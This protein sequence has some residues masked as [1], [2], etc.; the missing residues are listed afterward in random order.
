[1]SL[2]VS[3]TT[4]TAGITLASAN[5]PVFVTPGA[6]VFGTTASGF[7]GGTSAAWTVSNSGQVIAASFGISLKSGG[8]INNKASGTLF[9]GTDGIYAAGSLSA[10]LTVSNAGYIGGANTING[11][12][13]KEVRGAVAVTNLATGTIVGGYGGVYVPSG[14]GVGAI[15]NAGVVRGL[16][17]GAVVFNGGGG[18]TNASTG[19]ITGQEGIAINTTAGTLLNGGTIQGKTFQG[20]IFG[21]GGTVT[22]TAG[23]AIGGAQNGVQIST[24]AGTVTN[25][26]AI[27]GG[28]GTG[29]VLSAGGQLN[30]QGSGTIIGNSNGIYVSSGG[31][32]LVSAGYIAG[33]S[34]LSGSGIK[35]RTGAAVLSNLSGGTIVGGISGIYLVPGGGAGTVTNRGSISGLS[36]SGILLGAGGGV[37]NLG[38]GTITGGSYGVAITGGAGTVTNAGS[39]GGTLKAVSLAAGNA[40]RVIVDPGASFSGVVNG[41]NTIGAAAISTLELAA[42]GTLQAQ[43][44]GLGSQFINFAQVTVDAAAAWTLAGTNTLAAGTTLT[45]AGQLSIA[46]GSLSDAGSVINNGQIIDLSALK[47]GTLSGTGQVLIGTN[48]VFTTSGPVAASETIVFTGGGGL[49]TLVPTGFSGIIQGF[50]SGCAIDLSGISNA[51]STSIVNGNT[52][53]VTLASGGPINLTLAPDQVYNNLIFAIQAPGASFGTDD[54]IVVTGPTGP[55]F[56]AGGMAESLSGAQATSLAAIG[57]GLGGITVAGANSILTTAISSFAVGD[58][59]MGSLVIQSAGAVQSAVSATIAS[60]SGASGSHVNVSGIGSNWQV[61]GTLLV[62]DAGSGLLDIGTGGAVSADALQLG[63]QGAGGAGVVTLAGTGASLDVIGSVAVGVSGAGEFSVLNG[64][65]VTIGG[66]LNVAQLPGASGNV[67]IE[68]TTGTVTITGGITLGAGGGVAVLTIGTLT[69]VALTGG[70]VIG[71]HANLIKHTPFDPPPFV[72]NAGGDNEGSGADPYLAYIENTGLI[73]QDQ[74]TLIVQ[75]PT[76]YGAGGVFQINTNHSELVLNTGGVSGQTFDFTDNTGTLVIGVNQLPTIETP[77]TGTSGFT[78]VANPSQGLALIGSFGGTIGGFQPGD[79]IVVDAP[80]VAQVAYTAGNSFVSVVEA[81]NPLH[82]LGTLAFSTPANAAAAAGGSAIVTEVACFAA[83][84]R[85]L[86][87]RGAI[88]V[89]HLRE[90]DQVASAFGGTVPVVWLGHR[91]VDCRRHP[92]P[93]DVWPVRVHAGAFGPDLP[94]RDLLLS[95]DH[96]VYVDDVLIPVRYLLN[97]ATIAQ[98]PVDEVTYWHVELAQHDVILA[99]GLPAESYLDTGNRGAF[100]NAGGAVTMAPDFALRVWQ[101]EACAPLVTEGPALAAAR[102]RLL[103]RAEALGHVSTGDAALHVLAAGRPVHPLTGGTHPRFRLPPGAATLHFV[104][105]SGIPALMTPDTDDHRRLG[106]AIARITL[107]GTPIHLADPR[108]QAGWHGM[109][110]DADGGTLRWTD[111]DAVLTIADGGE[112]EVEVAMTARYWRAPAPRIAR[113]A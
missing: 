24:T 50:E 70:V 7:Y 87:D 36:S 21:N 26:G 48:S 6:Y 52:L 15:T 49:L 101:A 66:D 27:T 41:G 20:L 32:T 68:N 92:R 60:G 14:G 53:S 10:A 91:R 9:G 73:T 62:G 97:D 11:Y 83:G 23:G 96:A 28:T 34:P 30:N 25:S 39:I 105:R 31:L 90:G 74:G 63:G 4:S 59:T 98:T 95:P 113:V 38:G 72:S 51:T 55:T 99:E 16:R 44:A 106:I 80:V 75:T 110:T 84:T 64:A 43:I 69:S 8:I 76:I 3:G 12:G 35:V 100:A 86:T 111:G 45:N 85:I 58:T 77:A 79:V 18:I 46:N 71:A 54:V 89:E 1:M 108:L 67:D 81:A 17:F 104:S 37:V 56:V 78:T 109:E 22:N 47:V 112:L 82:V 65:N 2:I 19:T 33:T 93:R 103:A 88:P 29:V 42:G 102:R 40:N 107:N 13:I 61:A 57:T 94:S 5:N